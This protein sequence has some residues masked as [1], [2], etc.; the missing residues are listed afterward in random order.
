MDFRIN[1]KGAYKDAHL[2]KGQISKGDIF[3]VCIVTYLEEDVK[4]FIEDFWG[5]SNPLGR[6]GVRATHAKGQHGFRSRRGRT[7]PTRS[8]AATKYRSPHRSTNLPAVQAF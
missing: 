8:R 3:H 1:A 2:V 7:S 6:S 5:W 4:E